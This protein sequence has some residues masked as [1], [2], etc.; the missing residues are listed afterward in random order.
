MDLSGACND[1]EHHLEPVITLFD[2]HDL[3]N[4]R[5]AFDAPDGDGIHRRWP[6]ANWKTLWENYAVNL[7]HAGFVHEQYRRSP[8]VPMVDAN[9]RKT[10]EELNDGILKGAWIR[11]RGCHRRLS[12][13]AGR[14]IAENAAQS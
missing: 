3:D 13:G 10:F 9:A 4:F 5:L 11:H 14:R 2:D 12:V 6:Q 8:D 1:L 7:L